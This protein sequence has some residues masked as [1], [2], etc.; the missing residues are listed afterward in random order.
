MQKDQ[1]YVETALRYMHFLKYFQTFSN[2]IQQKC[3]HLPVELHTLKYSPSVTLSTVKN[4]VATLCY[5]LSYRYLKMGQFYNIFDDIS[6]IM[7]DRGQ[8]QR[9]LNKLEYM[10]K[11]QPDG[12]IS[13]KKIRIK[14]AYTPFS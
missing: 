5:F 13:L 3:L 9:G 12:F 8:S 6:I 7:N 2:Y 11:F 4:L 14:M 1:L 10:N